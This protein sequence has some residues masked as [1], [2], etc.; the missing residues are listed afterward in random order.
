MASLEN[1]EG[2]HITHGLL[3]VPCAMKNKKTKN[4][5]KRNGM[6]RYGTKRND[7]YRKDP[8]YFGI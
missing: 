8:H 2:R 1:K 6:K 7:K 4:R 3:Y 5:V